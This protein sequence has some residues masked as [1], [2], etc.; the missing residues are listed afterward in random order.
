MP[1]FKQYI[2][3]SCRWGIWKADETVEELLALLPHKEKYEADICGFTANSRKLERL[4]VRVLLY[5][6]LGEEKEIGYRSSG[7]PYLADGSASISIS[8]TKGY[9]AVLLGGPEKK[10]VLMS[11]VMANA[12]GKLLISSCGKMKVYL[13][14]KVRKPGRCCST[15]LQRKQ[16]LNV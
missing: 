5:E 6:M 4:A 16:C 12:Y 11:N 15:G 8:H 10:W 9:V 2:G 1:V 3:S 14:I 13:G 7:K